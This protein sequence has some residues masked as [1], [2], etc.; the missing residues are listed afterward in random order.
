MAILQ[1][2]RHCGTA[3]PAA[4][5]SQWHGRPSGGDS[6]LWPATAIRRAACQAPAAACRQDA[7][8]GARQATRQKSCGQDAATSHQPA[9]AQGTCWRCASHDPNQAAD[10][11]GR[12]EA[13]SQGCGPAPGRGADATAADCTAVWFCKRHLRPPSSGRCG[14]SACTAVPHA[15]GDIST[16]DN[17][18]CMSLVTCSAWCAHAHANMR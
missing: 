18:N 4:R 9:A 5:P 2:R 7:T 3:G 13:A 16:I 1:D 11:G 8:S 15:A 6:W 14:R 17:Q 12:Y 10:E